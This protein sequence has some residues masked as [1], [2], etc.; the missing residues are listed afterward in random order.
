MSISLEKPPSFGSI[1]YKG[2]SQVSLFSQAIALLAIVSNKRYLRRAIR[3]RP[4]D[5]GVMW[6]IALV[7]LS[8]VKLKITC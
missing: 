3:C 5:D 6:A 8:P 7:C 4:F 1:A 2:C